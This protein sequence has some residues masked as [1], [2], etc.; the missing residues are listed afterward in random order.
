MKKYLAISTLAVVMSCLTIAEASA[1]TRTGTV[2]GPRGTATITAAGG[3]AYGVCS[4]S[5]T[6][7]GPYGRTVTRTGSA[8]CVGGVCTASRVTTGPRGNTVYRY[9][10]FYR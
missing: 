8:S 4:R 2:T 3:C 6:R 7:T 5:V 1:W 10:T 9:G